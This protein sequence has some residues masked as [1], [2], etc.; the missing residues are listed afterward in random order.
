MTQSQKERLARRFVPNN[1]TIIDDGYCIVYKY[2]TAK[3]DIAAVGYVGTS[4]KAAFHFRFKDS[5]RREAFIKNWRFDRAAVQDRRNERKINATRP[6]TLKEGDILYSSWGY[7]QTNIDYYQVTKVI[8]K[9][10]VEIRE[11]GQRREETNFMQGNC[12]P[13]KDRFINEPMRKVV[14]TAYRDSVKVSE[15]ADAWLDEDPTKPKHWTA[16]A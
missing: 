10:T 11:I 3:G 13:V 2:E 16:Y 9:R 1:A 8:G 12:W 6:T 5:E 15:C 4:G 7:E 14:N